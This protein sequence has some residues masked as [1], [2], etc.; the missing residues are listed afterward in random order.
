MRL[1]G[2]GFLDYLYMGKQMMPDL[3]IQFFGSINLHWAV[4]VFPDCDLRH[5]SAIF[6]VRQ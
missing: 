2:L 4:Y 1:D 5:T 3:R 6:S